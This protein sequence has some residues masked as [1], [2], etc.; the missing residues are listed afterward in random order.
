LDGN[1]LPLN[2]LKDI[3]WL[4]IFTEE[5]AIVVSILLAFSI[6]AWWDDRQRSIDERVILKTLLSDLQDKRDLLV[7]QRA[8]DERRLRTN[9][10]LP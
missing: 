2:R 4:R 8:Q 6:N 1:Q 5:A 10:A 9:R 3:S 7:R